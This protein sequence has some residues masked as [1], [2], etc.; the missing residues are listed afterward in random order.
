MLDSQDCI[1]SN[2]G[3]HFEEGC[4]RLQASP[5]HFSL[6]RAPIPSFEQLVVDLESGLLTCTWRVLAVYIWAPPLQL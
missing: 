6:Q 1:T 2:S 4:T 5:R 3:S